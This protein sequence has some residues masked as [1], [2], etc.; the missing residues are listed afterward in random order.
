LSFFVSMVTLYA[1][2]QTRDFDQYRRGYYI[3]NK[4]DT[5]VGY[6]LYVRGN[7]NGRIEYFATGDKKAKKIHPK[8]CREFV[9]SD[10]IKFIRVDGKFSVKAGIGM[11]D[12]VNDFIEVLETGKVNL[13]MH[14]G[15]S[16]SAN[17]GT[18]LDWDNLVVKR[19]SSAYIGLHPNL[20][21]RRRE[22]EKQLKGEDELI[23]ILCRETT[24]EIREGIKE[25][26]AK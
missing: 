5:L 3:N 9:M 7:N 6:V 16:G 25:Y 24:N 1:T 14:H 26:N 19:D 2:A 11:I 8:D 4:G 12:I 13:Y 21:K 22:V 15:I 18:P 23:E 20:D 17:F 10:T